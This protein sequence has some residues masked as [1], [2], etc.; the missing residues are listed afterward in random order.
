MRLFLDT[1]FS[2]LGQIN[3][4]LISLALVDESGHHTFYAEMPPSAY[5]RK[6]SDW[7]RQM[8]IPW[9]WGGRFELP[10]Q[11]FKAQLR[12]F[13]ENLNVPVEIVTDSPGYD[14]EL[15]LAPL[16]NPWPDNLAKAPV[17]FDPE[18]TGSPGLIE[19][20][21]AYHTPARPQHHALHDANALLLAYLAMNR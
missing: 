4:V 7:V 11:D 10:P 5:E 20:M 19:M 18:T 1:E 14:F 12:A 6:S 17:R 8:V 2:G 21:R 3:P 13:I 9:L 15:M 16:L